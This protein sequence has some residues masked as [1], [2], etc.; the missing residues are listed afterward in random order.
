MFSSL[1]GHPF[2]QPGTLFSLALIYKI[3]VKINPRQRKIGLKLKDMI[4]KHYLFYLIMLIT[5]TGRIEVNHR[6]IYRKEYALKSEFL[7]HFVDY[8][9]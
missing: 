4:L 1:L 7:Y 2:S 8:V 6:R 5:L 9:H 3:L